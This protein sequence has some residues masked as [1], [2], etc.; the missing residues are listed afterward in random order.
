[1]AKQ[2][3]SAAKGWSGSAPAVDTYIPDITDPANIEDA[4]KLFMYGTDIDGGEEQVEGDSLYSTIKTIKTTATTHATT[5]QGI[6][7][8]SAS[9]SIVGTSDIQTLSNKTI[10]NPV[11][12]GTL[13]VSGN[14]TL[15][16]NLNVGGDASVDGSL[17][18]SVNIE[19]SGNIIGHLGIATSTSSYTLVLE[20]D[21]C[22]I[23]MNSSSANTLTVP[24]NSSV[25]FP[26]G[27]QITVVQKGTGQT[28]ITAG[29]GVTVNS[30][31]LLKLRAQWSAAS[32]IKTA[33]DTWLVAGDL[34]A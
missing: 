15:D 14:T 12:N 2:L 13:D 26:V 23:E 8:V 16:S 33:T 24:P 28:T 34:S 7:G 4:F 29:S 22:L 31:L 25:A 27:T 3:L 9:S 32:L 11:V 19:A 30:P 5:S 6:H 1:M 18:V 20:D 21:G 10:V 17:S